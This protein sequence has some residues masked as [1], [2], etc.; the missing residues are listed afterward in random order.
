MHRCG[1]ERIYLGQEKCRKRIANR[2]RSLI[3][4]EVR[5]RGREM[6]GERGRI[7]N[8]PDA[9]QFTSRLRD[10]LSHGTRSCISAKIFI[11]HP[12][13][14]YLVKGQIEALWEKKSI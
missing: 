13:Y 3:E 1:S 9:M 10:W 6:E 12:I 2:K 11:Y 7:G 5:K 4:N 8:R 14:I